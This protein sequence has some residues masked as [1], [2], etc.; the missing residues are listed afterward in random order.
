M[1]IAGELRY[2]P[3]I[4]TTETL[5]PIIEEYAGCCGN[6]SQSQSPLFRRQPFEKAKQAFST[7]EV[8]T[9]EKCG[10]LLIN[11]KRVNI[12]EITV[13]PHFSSL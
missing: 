4:V 10:T 8:S 9:L 12:K 3:L 6:I 7:D 5:Y 1:T 13:T 11:I 2:V